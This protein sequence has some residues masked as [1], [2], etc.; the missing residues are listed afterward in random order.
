MAQKLKIDLG[1]VGRP[2]ALMQTE[3][4]QQL[5]VTFC[6]YIHSLSSPNYLFEPQ[7]QANI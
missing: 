3:A 5:A 6:T 2:T 1:N 7:H 4:S